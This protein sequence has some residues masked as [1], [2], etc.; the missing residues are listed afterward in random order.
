MS[1][2]RIGADSALERIALSTLVVPAMRSESCAPDEWADYYDMASFREGVP[3]TRRRPT[4]GRDARPLEPGDVLLS[5]LVALPRRAWVVAA[6]RGRPQFASYD[7]LVLRSA[8][9]DPVYLRHLLVSNEFHLRFEHAAM[10]RR[11]RHAVAASDVGDI[12]I[13]MPSRE[14]QARLGRVLQHADALRSKRQTV[15]GRLARLP[16]AAAMEM[17]AVAR[18]AG[19]QH[20]RLGALRAATVR[21]GKWGRDAT[22]P[23]LLLRAASV[24]EDGV[25][26]AGCVQV[27]PPDE[28]THGRIVADGDLLITRPRDA[29]RARVAVARP[30]AACWLAHEELLQL[31]VDAARVDPEYVRAVVAVDAVCAP[32][33]ATR[34]SAERFAR[35]V[36]KVLVPVPAPAAQAR[37][38]ALAAAARALGAKVQASALK[39]DALLGVLRDAAFR[40]E[41]AS[42]LESAADS[43]PNS[44]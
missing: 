35:R 17:R 29:E 19:W 5:R 43:P 44:S 1:R 40:G 32:A 20:V 6:A 26:C 15:A 16:E 37:L 11:R 23:W 4:F 8:R 39:L 27:S 13:P 9:F 34:T 7:W 21:G 33:P 24:G 42:D 22:G 41:L 36:E 38:V 18:D 2:E 25:D 14:V 30:G 31:T 3:S 10:R 28:G 12:P